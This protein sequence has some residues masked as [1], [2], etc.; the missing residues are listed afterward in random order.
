MRRVQAQRSKKAEGR[1]ELREVERKEEGCEDK[2]KER[3][4]RNEPSQRKER[5]RW[6]Y[7]F[8]PDFSENVRVSSATPLFGRVL[9]N[10]SPT[11]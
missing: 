3:R 6:R 11:E 10:A 1:R 9:K 5:R 8:T 7:A 2:Y 4:R